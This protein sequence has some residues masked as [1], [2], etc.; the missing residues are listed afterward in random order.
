M[1]EDLRFEVEEDCFLGFGGEWCG[2]RGCSGEIGEIAVFVVDGKNGRA[3][4]LSG[5]D[6]ARE[7]VEAVLGF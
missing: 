6:G 3:V 1:G 5:L 2:W 7:D 4:L